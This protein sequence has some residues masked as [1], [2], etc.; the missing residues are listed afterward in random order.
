MTVE[1]EPDLERVEGVTERVR[2]RFRLER[3]R[4]RERRGEGDLFRLGCRR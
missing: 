2:R 3:S 1:C 4:S